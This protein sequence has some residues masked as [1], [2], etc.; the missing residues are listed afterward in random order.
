MFGQAL[1]STALGGLLALHLKAS[2]PALIAAGLV[3][4]G[5][6]CSAMRM[7]VHDPEV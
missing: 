3:V 4:L 6:L 5:I 2:A 7:A 1:G